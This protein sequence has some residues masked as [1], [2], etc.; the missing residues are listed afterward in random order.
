MILLVRCSTAPSARRPATPAA[1]EQGEGRGVG[2]E[3]DWKDH[4]APSVPGSSLHHQMSFR[5]TT[6]A[7]PGMVVG[8][9][10]MKNFDLAANP[11]RDMLTYRV[12]LPRG[13]RRNQSHLWSRP[14]RARHL[15]ES[16]GVT[17]IT[18]PVR[19]E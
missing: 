3:G 6:V 19:D 11:I 13:R 16:P 8:T 15:A 1:R 14:N 17:V 18:V 5:D 4:V 10:K 9:L 12:P 2:S 7:G